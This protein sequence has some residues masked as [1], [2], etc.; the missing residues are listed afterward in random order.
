MSGLFTVACWLVLF[1]SGLAR[2]DDTVTATSPLVRWSG[3]T[4]SDPTNA[5]VSFDWEGTRLS[6]A[7]SGATRVVANLTMFTSSTKFHVFVGNQIVNTFHANGSTEEYVLVDDLDKRIRVD[8]HGHVAVKGTHIVTLYNAIEPVFIYE[9]PIQGAE[10]A[11]PKSIYRSLPRGT[12]SVDY[13]SVAPT[14][15]SLSTDG[16]FVSPPAKRSKKM[17]FIGDSITAGYG[18]VGTD[19]CSAGLDTNDHASAYGHLL[20]TMFD[21]ECVETIAWS[22]KGMVANCCGIEGE[23]MPAEYHHTFGGNEG[24]NDWDFQSSEQPDVVIINLGTNDW[25]SI[26]ASDPGFAQKYEDEYVALVTNITQKYYVNGPKPTIF[27]GVGPMS[28]AYQPSVE[29]V[30]TR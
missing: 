26:Y 12:V 14:V 21:A 16:Q 2:A 8:A 23:L 15:N 18:A 25:N 5:R 1:T 17:A 7:V 13:S 22:G 28:T 19:P 24:S 27:L 30:I 6:V 11:A 20:C 9:Q 29:A 10:P 3:R 4:R